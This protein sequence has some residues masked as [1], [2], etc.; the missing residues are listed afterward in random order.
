MSVPQGKL[1]YCS[2][3]GA[4]LCSMCAR[5]GANLA[6]CAMT[7]SPKYGGDVHLRG[8]PWPQ[9]ERQEEEGEP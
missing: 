5:C 2:H 8:C 6:G 7:Y 4:P 9:R 3:C 1:D